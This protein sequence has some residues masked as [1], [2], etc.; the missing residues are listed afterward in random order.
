M[1]E[2]KDLQQEPLVP[3][4][5]VPATEAPAEPS[6]SAEPDT[7]ESVIAPATDDPLGFINEQLNDNWLSEFLQ[8]KQAEEAAAQTLT[9]DKIIDEQI[10]AEGSAVVVPAE[11]EWLEQKPAEEEKEIGLDMSAAAAAGLVAPEDRELERILAENWGD[12]E[13]EPDE[14]APAD[15]AAPQEAF[16]VEE[17]LPVALSDEPE[18]HQDEAAPQEEIPEETEYE[19]D[20]EEENMAQ[21]QKKRRP[22]M[23]KDGGLGG[24]LHSLPHLLVTVIWLAIIVM[25]AVPVGRLLWMGVA[26]VMAFGKEPHE[27]TVTIDA[28]DTTEEIAQKLGDAELIR[29]PWLFQK[30]AELTGKDE[31]IDPGTYTLNAYLDYNA[32]LRNMVN[33]GPVQEIVTVMFPEG[34]NCAQI[35]AKLEENGVCTVAELEEYAAN[36]ELDEYWFLEGVE[37]GSKYCLEGYLAPDTYE[38]Y[39]NDDPGRVLEKFLNAFD[40]RFTD[41]MRDE[42]TKMQERYAKALAKN[43]YG[44]SYIESHPLTLHKVVTL[45][46]IVQK[47]TANDNESYTIASVFYNRLTNPANHPY[48]GS[49]ATVYYA[50]GDYFAESGELTAEQLAFDSPYNTRNNPGLPPGPIC[51]PGAYS[52]YA[53]LEPDETTYY[54][55]IYSPKAGEHLF[56]STL[57]EHEQKAKELE[58]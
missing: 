9:A 1:D 42:L 27:V 11:L 12:P 29:Y 46:S 16:P 20:E 26:D 56:S 50:I 7:F 28:D 30:F 52:L 37:R 17:E 58:N 54:Y 24:L 4:E 14:E 3:E 19:A 34:Y 43:G 41:K 33:R 2:K 53:A 45:A 31:R 57:R 32:M 40:A 5:N 13:P 39:T 15:P 44:Q 10:A 51:N 49:D 35:F 21:D 48:L 8:K 25:I 23:N 36:G 6:P 18:Q 55:F 38:F 47:E 22:K